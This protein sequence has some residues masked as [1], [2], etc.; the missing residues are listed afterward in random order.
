MGLRRQMDELA[1][2]PEGASASRDDIE[3]DGLALAVGAAVRT[4]RS[5]AGLTMAELGSRSGVTQA[6]VSQLESGRS[7][8]SLI[9]LHR[10]AQA[11]GVSAQ[12]LL[13]DNETEAVSLIRAGQGREYE[14][15]EAHGTVLERFLVSGRRQMEPGE[16]WAEPGSE[17]GDFLSHNGEELLYV[18]EGRIR[19]H[20]QGARSEVLAKGDCLYYPASIPH[21][22][23]VA[24]QAR[25]G[26]LVIATPSSF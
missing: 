1:Q 7:M 13:P 11:L 4:A 26:F 5:R 17:S 3:S 12:S 10:I 24:G 9:T 21:R 16:V 25:A 8:P 19:V 22:W 20:L 23:E 2:A 15:S 14:R 6:F 18:L